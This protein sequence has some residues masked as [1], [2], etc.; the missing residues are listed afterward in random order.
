MPRRKTPGRDRLDVKADPAL[1]DL[2]ATAAQAARMD[3]SSYVRRA[4]VRQLKEDGYTV[5]PPT[6]PD[7]PPDGPATKT[8]DSREAAPKRPRG[9][10]RKTA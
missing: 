7:R 8:T 2:V 4:L 5:P 6:P 1:L 3:L 10:P 9:R